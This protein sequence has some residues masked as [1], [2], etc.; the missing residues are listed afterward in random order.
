MRA[1][2]SV[3]KITN[4]DKQN[5][6]DQTN[7]KVSILSFS[8]IWEMGGLYIV[9]VTPKR[10]KGISVKYFNAYIGSRD[11]TVE[12]FSF[13]YPANAKPFW[14]RDAELY[15]VLLCPQSNRLSTGNQMYQ[16]Q[17]GWLQDL[18]IC[19]KKKKILDKMWESLEIYGIFIK[20]Y[21]VSQRLYALTIG[22]SE[23]IFHFSSL[24]T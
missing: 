4:T 23:F 20:F 1:F 18:Q 6:P 17:T 24:V 19:K 13:Q 12:D 10:M 8:I 9:E 22:M 2:I 11:K 14:F 5:D 21:V 15:C 3:G 16:N 7:P